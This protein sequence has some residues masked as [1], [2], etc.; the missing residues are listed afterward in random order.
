[1]HY[2]KL[3]YLKYMGFCY[4]AIEKLKLQFT[5]TTYNFNSPPAC[6]LVLYA[7]H[8]C[9]HIHTY[10]HEHTLEIVITLFLILHCSYYD[11]PVESLPS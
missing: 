8:T 5:S 4:C 7:Q 6:S 10:A 9:V 3:C 2:K 11:I 1:M